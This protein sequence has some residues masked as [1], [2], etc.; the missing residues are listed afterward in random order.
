MRS[1]FALALAGVAAAVDMDVKFLHHLS[2]FGKRYD[3]MEE[4]LMRL[5]NFMRAEAE[6]MKHNASGATSRMGHN[7]FS[8]WTQEEFERMLGFKTELAQ[9]AAEYA[10]WEPTDEAEVDWVAA[11]AVTG[12]KDQGTCGSCWSFSTTGSMEGAHQIATGE[13]IALS[14]QQFVDCSHNGNLGCMGGD[15]GRA[16]K[17]AESNAIESE[18]DYPYKGWSLGGCKADASKGRVTV[19]DYVAVTPESSEA[20]KAQIAKGPVSVAIQANQKVFQRYSGGIIT[21][22]CGTNLDH[23]VLA[24]GFG[25]EDGVEFIRVKNSW[26]TSWGEDGYVRIAVEDGKGVCGINMQPT[27]PTTN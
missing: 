21:E 24:V 3:T 16:F 15:M 10:D 14:E 23:G 19:S 2:L 4:Y 8:D 11:G 18:D 27:Q 17:W 1:A 12:V 20:L 13:L 22:G 7:Q 5:E 26:N 9:P 25:S 6:I